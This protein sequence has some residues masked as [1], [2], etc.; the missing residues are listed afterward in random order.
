MK[1]MI[2]KTWESYDRI[3][4]LD[5]WIVKTS[6]GRELTRVSQDDRVA[7]RLQKLV[8][9]H[10]QEITR[11]D[12]LDSAVRSVVEIYRTLQHALENDDDKTADVALA[13]LDVAI[14]AMDRARWG[15]LE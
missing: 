10:N 15:N 7:R 5:V 12:A 3:G 9:Q 6:D 13:E 4:N 14:A 8:E 11:L 1:W 2:V